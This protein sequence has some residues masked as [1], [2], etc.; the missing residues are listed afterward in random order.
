MVN[1]ARRAHDVLGMSWATIGHLLDRDASA[2][3][4]AVLAKTSTPVIREQSQL[5]PCRSNYFNAG[6]K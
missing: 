4:R 2:L 5:A 6:P 3:R 1:I